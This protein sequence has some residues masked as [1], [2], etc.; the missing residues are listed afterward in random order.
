MR[1]SATVIAAAGLLIAIGLSP[2]VAGSAPA[3]QKAAVQK[4]CRAEVPAELTTAPAHWLGDCPN[5]MAEGLGVT[6]AGGAA[7]YE[8]F[9]GRMRDGQ[10]V[11]GVL[12]LKSGLMMVAIRFDAQRRVVVSDGLRP[13]E[14]EAVFRTAT[15][16]A[17]AVSKRMAATGNRSSA[18]YY[19]GLAKR[20][21]NAPPE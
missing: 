3:R 5:G 6:R 11:D 10:L 13:S 1:R 14:D 16:A 8:F 20:I 2:A 12:V 19:T 15:A 9:A 17:E 4:P 21:R 18:A 7:P